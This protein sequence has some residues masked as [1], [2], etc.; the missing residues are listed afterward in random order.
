MTT[1]TNA[2]NRVSIPARRPDEPGFGALLT[3]A[4]PAVRDAAVLVYAVER[5]AA[6]PLLR[7]TQPALWLRLRAEA[8]R[9]QASDG[10]AWASGRRLPSS[11]SG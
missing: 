9:L 6:S 7:M 2:L 5:F 10:T 11:G 8:S 3:A 1:E 4:D